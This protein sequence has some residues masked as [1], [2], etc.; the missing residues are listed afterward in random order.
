[1]KQLIF[2]NWDKKKTLEFSFHFYAWNTMNAKIEMDLW[3]FP[4]WMVVYTYA[5]LSS[6]GFSEIYY[7]ILYFGQ[8]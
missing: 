3:V 2:P 5:N 7:S 1:M 6:N 4:V 8:E